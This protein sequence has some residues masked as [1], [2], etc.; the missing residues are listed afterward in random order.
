MPN[1]SFVNQIDIESTQNYCFVEYQP[2]GFCKIGIDVLS[3]LPTERHRVINIELTSIIDI[4]R[5]IWKVEII[6]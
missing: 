5:S 1:L 3:I 6:S 4:L 2:F